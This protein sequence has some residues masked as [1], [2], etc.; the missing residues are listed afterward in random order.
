M[1]LRCEAKP[2]RQEEL[3]KQIQMLKEFKSYVVDQVKKFSQEIMGKPEEF[4]T[5]TVISQS[6]LSFAVNS[7]S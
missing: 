1:I 2:G 4:L 3:T 5:V 7:K 6:E